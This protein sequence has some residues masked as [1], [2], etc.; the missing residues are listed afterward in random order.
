MEKVKKT[1][2]G[3]GGE[4][5]EDGEGGEGGEGGEDGCPSLLGF[6]RVTGQCWLSQWVSFCSAVPFPLSPLCVTLAQDMHA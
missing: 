1:E 3:E 4:D 2:G 5:G 6:L